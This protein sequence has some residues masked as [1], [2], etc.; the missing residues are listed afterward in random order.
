MFAPWTLTILATVAF[1]SP[2]KYETCIVGDTPRSP[3][4]GCVTQV[5]QT[6]KGDTYQVTSLLLG[7]RDFPDG[8]MRTV[9]EYKSAQS[10]LALQWLDANHLR[11]EYD[12]TVP[13]AKVTEQI[14][15]EHRVIKLIYVP[16]GGSPADGCDFERDNILNVASLPPNNSFKPNPLRGS[17]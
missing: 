7:C 16:R 14:P 17:A 15:L 6:R 13:L 9:F 12:S 2:S 11:V 5:L 8:T 1:H 4:H 3:D 10:G